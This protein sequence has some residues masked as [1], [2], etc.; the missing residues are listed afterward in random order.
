MQHIDIANLCAGSFRDPSG[1]VYFGDDCVYRTI[2]ACYADEWEQ[3]KKSGFFE[4]ALAKKLILPFE[5]LNETTSDCY[6]IL[7]SPLLPFV[8]YPY[9]WSFGQYKD[10]AL[11]TLDVLDECLKFG[12]VLKDATAYNIQFLDGKPVFI[13]LLSFAVRDMHKPWEAYLQYCKHFLAPLALMAKRSVSCGRMMETWIEG[14]PLDLVSSILPWKTKLSA[15]LG[16]HIHMHAKMQTKYGD[17]RQAKEKVRAVS[18][19]E[20]A[21]QKLSQSLRYAVNSLELP[22]SLQT[23][24]GDY[25]NDTNYT[26]LGAEDKRSYL[27][28]IASENPQKTLAADLGANQGVYSRFLSKYYAKVLALDIDYLAVE[29]FY[30]ALKS[31]EH[32]NIL[33]L[34]FDLGNP[35]PNIGW[36]NKERMTFIERCK[37]SYV[38][39]LALVHHLCFTAGIPLF[40]IAEYFSTIIETK[41][42]LAFE[43]VPLED[44]QV[45]RLLAVRENPFPDYNLSSCIAE[46][47][48]YFALVE[49]HQVTDSKRTILIFKKM[50]N[51]K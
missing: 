4:S 34:V 15:S 14:L 38:S 48:K 9:E 16:I 7:K 32:T 39:A 18:L 28:K 26:E 13:D 44:S 35:S 43:F 47:S 10:A 46:F 11:H 25:Y 30:Q 19:K 17:A 37:A 22:Q 40:K 45:Q 49:Q 3:I 20:D 2:N 41:G 5:E 29:K 8:S 23:E 27:E 12:L 6:N 36:A 33:P 24:W 1:A 51:S 21:L 31:E 42:I 50:E